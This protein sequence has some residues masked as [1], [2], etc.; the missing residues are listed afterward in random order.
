MLKAPPPTPPSDTNIEEL[1]RIQA[2]LAHEQARKQHIP[3]FTDA[4]AK[5]GFS[6]LGWLIAKGVVR[7]EQ[8]ANI[9]L[10][11]VSVVCIGLSLWFMFR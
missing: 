7:T 11:A 8:Q 10:I 3:G 4:S 9:L 6:I 1:A 2:E 5:G